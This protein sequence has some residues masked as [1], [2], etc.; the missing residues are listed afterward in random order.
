MCGMAALSAA[1]LLGGCSKVKTLA[2]INFDVPYSQQISV[3]SSGYAYGVP[4]PGG[5][6]TLPFPAIPVATN[7]Q[8]YIAQYRTSTDK[9]LMVNL[10]KMSLQIE[11]PVGQTFD[12]MDNISVYLSAINQPEMLVA[13]QSSI[14][15]GQTTLNFDI[16]GNVNLKNYFIADTIYFRLTTHINAVPPTGEQLQLNTTFHVLANPLE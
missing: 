8:Q 5:G 3:P 16:P 10:T 14:A 9:I 6:V 2:N 12:F 15:K 1:V 7:S 13:S 11:S 4:L